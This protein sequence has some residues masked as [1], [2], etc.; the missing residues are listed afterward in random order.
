MPI[1]NDI[2]LKLRTISIAVFLFTLLLASP[3][4]SE[5]QGEKN[6]QT[7]DSQELIALDQ[8]FQSLFMNE[9]FLGV[10]NLIDQFFTTHLPTEANVGA[11]LVQT[12]AYL[13]LD[14]K[15]A[16]IRSLEKA[17]PVLTKLN[18][19]AR[20]KY[21]HLYFLLGQL[22]S[23][24]GTYP[25][26]ISYVKD[27][28][29]LES[30]N[31]YNQI[32]LG[33]LYKRLGNNSLAMSHFQSLLELSITTEEERSVIREKLHQISKKKK[34]TL[35]NV[36]VAHALLHKK[37]GYK[38]VP[39]NHFGS[40]VNLEDI[41]ILL[42][43]KFHVPCEILPR[44]EL[45]E[46]IILNTQRNQYDGSK[47]HKELLKMFVAPENR[48]FWVIGITGKDI[49][50]KNTNYVF[51]LQNR[52]LKIGVIST[53]RFLAGLDDFTKLILSQPEDLAF[54]SSPPWVASINS[55]DL[56]RP[57]VH[58]PIQMTSKNS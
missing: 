56:L 39:L 53:F 6:L 4:F 38:I 31:I 15:K 25:K 18:N 9:D 40:Q 55:P 23:E 22:Y 50:S 14:K 27:G 41:C 46:K 43:S 52:S 36:D 21:S 57:I 24:L 1:M 44:I 54:N 34:I 8:Q 2:R 32:F 30:Q 20:R 37:V 51:S 3:S 28:L 49:F 19:V 11:L 16:A 33:E 10:V 45:N 7:T 13:M 12:Q 29:R 47:I 5:D 17:L 58:W 42:E 26:A 48:P 35:Q